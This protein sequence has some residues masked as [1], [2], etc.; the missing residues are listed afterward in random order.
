[1]SADMSRRFKSVWL[2]GKSSLFGNT[3]TATVIKTHV[4]TCLDIKTRPPP[5]LVLPGIYA[6]ADV[7]R[8]GP[9]QFSH[10]GKSRPPENSEKP[11]K[12][13]KK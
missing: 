3:D 12:G 7:S 8:P 2:K 1:M 10:H 9:G 11:G 6:G 13:A 5:P 4:A